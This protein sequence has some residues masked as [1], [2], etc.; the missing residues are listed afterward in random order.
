MFEYLFEVA[1]KLQNKFDFF[2]FPSL[3]LQENTL[4]LNQASIILNHMQ[5]LQ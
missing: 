3:K 5:L 4:V 2:L 1:Q